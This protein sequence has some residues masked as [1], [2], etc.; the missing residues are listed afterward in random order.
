MFDSDSGRVVAE[1]TT[2]KL[3]GALAKAQAACRSA[4]KDAKNNHQGYKYAS[5]EEILDAAK[6]ALGPV[7]V[8]VFPESS[9]VF[10]IDL[11][12][13]AA[14]FLR[15]TFRVACEGEERVAALVWPV[16]PGPGRPLDKALASA[17]TS[18]LAY[19]LRDLLAMPRVDP[20][21]NMDHT[22]RRDEEQQHGRRAPQS[23]QQHQPSPPSSPA[24]TPSVPPPVSSP[25]AGAA[26]PSDS[27]P[28][29]QR[30]DGGDMV[31]DRRPSASTATVATAVVAPLQRQPVQ[32]TSETAVANPAT[33]TGAARPSDGP[34][35][36]EVEAASLL[37]PK[38]DAAIRFGRA[39]GIGG[40]I[41][42]AVNGEAEALV[43]AEATA[44]AWRKAGR[45]RSRV[46]TGGQARLFVVY[47]NE[48][49][50]EEKKKD[51]AP[52]AATP[53]AAV[54]LTPEEE[55][56]LSAPDDSAP[57]RGE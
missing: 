24:P 42:R 44:A 53:V 18:S 33:V 11:P 54:T 8:S 7:G 5:A 17:D 34:S 16:V 46:P 35:P 38:A 57:W 28:L 12:S 19:F 25:P 40:E 20:T 36:L 1:A 10:A 55:E 56:R 6:E 51:E 13:G 32:A 43:G 39:E 37:G 22:D 21:D 47:V 30:L 52:K 41:A 48:A 50:Y 14:T 26:P 23:R 3:N 45:A 27:R 49:L 31:E 4:S 9:D 15:R 29:H 2:T